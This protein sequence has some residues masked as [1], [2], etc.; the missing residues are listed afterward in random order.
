MKRQVAIGLVL[1][2][3]VGL[4]GSLSISA[5][6]KIYTYAGTA[7]FDEGYTI[8]RVEDNRFSFAV[9][10]GD[11]AYRFE[12]DMHYFT[13]GYA[14]TE[15]KIIGQA[16]SPEIIS[17]Y[18]LTVNDVLDSFVLKENRH[19]L[20]VVTRDGST[21]RDYYKEIPA[22]IFEGFIATYTG[23]LDETGKQALVSSIF[24]RTRFSKQEDLPK[25]YSSP[26]RPTHVAAREY[27][28]YGEMTAATD[29]KNNLLE[30]IG[31]ERFKRVGTG[32]VK[33]MHNVNNAPRRGIV[34]QRTKDDLFGQIY[35]SGVVWDLDA[36]VY[37]NASQ[38]DKRTMQWDLRREYNFLVIYDIK[39]DTMEAIFQDKSAYITEN[40]YNVT[41]RVGGHDNFSNFVDFSYGVCPPGSNPTPSL[42]FVKAEVVGLL[43]KLPKYA[44]KAFKYLAALDKAKRYAQG[45]G[46]FIANSNTSAALKDFQLTPPED[47]QLKSI[48]SEFD[49]AAYLYDTGSQ[50]SAWAKV[51]NYAPN[52]YTWYDFD[53]SFKVF[54]GNGLPDEV[55]TFSRRLNTAD[56]D[57]VNDRPLADGVYAFKNEVTQGALDA[58][59]SNFNNPEQNPAVVTNPDM[60]KRANQLWDVSFDA[61]AN[62]YII[63]PAYDSRLALTNNEQGYLHVSEYSGAANQHFIISQ[64]PDGKVVITSQWGGNYDSPLST[65]SDESL[66]QNVVSCPRELDLVTTVWF[67]IPM[68]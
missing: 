9:S 30:E 67:P 56:F 65:L 48:S 28:E 53:F 66:Y 68:S 8:E 64:A 26:N 62:A 20:R 57:T 16:N 29:D 40:Y 41:L 55:I 12:A 4:F 46:N 5:E 50:L 19:V 39:S 58:C 3:L 23:G 59:V 52:I 25:R 51:D 47:C 13:D 21:S 60:H 22:S 1:A 33:L 18:V 42:S 34:L 11:S 27:R 2:V 36:K 61:A 49:R 6:E 43:K 35:T 37:H 17:V 54:G 32:Y 14:F 15:K 10:A 44:G 31:Y 24:W 45:I 63:R 38:T 7:E